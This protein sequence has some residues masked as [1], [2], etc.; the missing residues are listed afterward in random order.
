VA[1]PLVWIREA[2]ERRDALR[3]MGT[4]LTIVP[5]AE[6]VS[7]WIDGADVDLVFRSWSLFEAAGSNPLIPTIETLVTRAKRKAS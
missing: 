6:G 5:S 3:A 2:Y 7:V 4:P 1:A